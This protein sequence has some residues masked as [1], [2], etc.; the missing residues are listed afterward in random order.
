M[1]ISHNHPLAKHGLVIGQQIYHNGITYNVEFE[2]F[3][4]YEINPIQPIIAWK[5][6]N[7]Y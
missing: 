3:G 6:K 7:C 5:K 1:K 4:K 2:D